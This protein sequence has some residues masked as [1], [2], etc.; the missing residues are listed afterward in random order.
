MLGT[1]VLKSF[2]LVFIL[3][4]V[5]PNISANICQDIISWSLPPCQAN[6]T[7]SVNGQD[8][9]TVPCSDGNVNI[10]DTNVSISDTDLMNNTVTVTTTDQLGKLVK[11]P[12][13]SNEG[14]YVE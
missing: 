7:V 10:G 5:P 11:I 1:T 6:C 9:E 12:V 4:T 2:D 13:K 14:T 8:I 3:C